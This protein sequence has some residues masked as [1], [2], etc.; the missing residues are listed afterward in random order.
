MVDLHGQPTMRRGSLFDEEY[1]R[2]TTLSQLPLKLVFFVQ[3]LP[4][5]FRQ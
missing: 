3:M 5:R 2:L 4:S 1:D